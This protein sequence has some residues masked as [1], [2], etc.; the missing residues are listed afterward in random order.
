[1]RRED[2]SEL[3]TFA[4]IAEQRSFTRAANVLGVSPSALSHAM[5]AFEA[6]LGVRLLNR[7]T[8][9]VAPTE[10]GRNLLQKLRPAM[11]GVEAALEALNDGRDRPAG[12]VRVSAH[13]TAAT[14][15]LLPRLARFADD[16]PQIEV[17]LVIEDG[18]VDI[19][20]GGFDAGVRHEQML[21]ADMVC[22]RIGPAQRLLIV[23]T[24]DHLARSGMPLTPED[25]MHHRCLNYRY[26]SSGV[27]HPWRFER[28]GREMVI[29]A[30]GPFVTNNVDVLLEAALRGIGVACVPE[31][32]AERHLAAG[33]LASLLRE[34]CPLLP[35]NYLYY[36]SR[37][38]NSAAF[39]AFVKALQDGA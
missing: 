34:W 26:T 32:Q 17:E 25:L 9:S 24:P 1:M 12:R 11:A 22:V 4:A 7:T 37:R 29:A 30:P 35:P 5:R 31:S 18:L 14:H 38:Q 13:R 6:R 19:V 33:T 2:W 8:R 36:P 27:I 16:Y 10:A 15:V 3:V 39:A 23:A 28:H 21:D 20:A